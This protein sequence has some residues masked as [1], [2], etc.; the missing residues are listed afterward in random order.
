METSNNDNIVVNVLEPN[1]IINTY[2]DVKIIRIKS[3]S[4][5][6]TIM[7]DYWP[8]VGELDGSCYIESDSTISFENISGFYSMS[9]NVFNLIIKK[10]HKDKADYNF[11]LDLT[12]KNIL[13]VD[14]A[15]INLRLANNILSKYNA[16]VTLSNGG[17]SCLELLS[18]GKHF[19]LIMLDEVMPDLSGLDTLKQIRSLYPD[20]NTPILALTSEAKEGM[21]VIYKINGFDGYLF[22]PFHIKDVEKMLFR[23]CVNPTLPEKSE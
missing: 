10:Y 5:N 6:L 16:N 19:D 2:N 9:H 18:E 8:V 23:C 12:G 17:N 14:D 15:K 13:V 1:T 4:T 22:K 3:R 20:M 7:K 21:D 11:V